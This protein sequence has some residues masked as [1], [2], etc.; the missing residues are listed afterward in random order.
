MAK[1]EE[2]TKFKEKYLVPQSKDA[3]KMWKDVLKE[4]NKALEDWQK[5]CRKDIADWE[6]ETKVSQN[7]LNISQKRLVDN[8]N[9]RKRI[10]KEIS[11]ARQAEEEISGTEPDDESEALLQEITKQILEHEKSITLTKQNISRDN[12]SIEKARNDI[13]KYTDQIE[14]ITT[15]LNSQESEHYFKL[16]EV[17][18][19]DLRDSIGTH[20]W[21]DQVFKDFQKE[22][23]KSYAFANDY[24]SVIADLKHHP[25][26]YK[27]PLMDGIQI[28]LGTLDA[29]YEQGKRSFDSSE[30]LAAEESL[31]ESELAGKGKIVPPVTIFDFPNAKAM[32]LDMGLTKDEVARLPIKGGFSC[33]IGDKD[34][35]VAIATKGITPVQLA[36]AGEKAAADALKLHLFAKAR[37][38]LQDL[39]NNEITSPEAT[40]LWQK[41]IDAA[42][43]V[44][45]NAAITELERQFRLGLQST[46]A[47]IKFGFS[48]VGKV[49][50]AT[51]AVIGVVL[52]GMVGNVAGIVLGVISAVKSVISLIKEV[53][54]FCADI[55]TVIA[56]ATK[57]IDETL[58]KFNVSK[59][60]LKT[61]IAGQLKIKDG[62]KGLTSKFI[63]DITGF[64][65][66]KTFGK[67]SEFLGSARDKMNNMELKQHDTSR[68]QNTALEVQSTLQAQIKELES[69]KDV[70]QEIEKQISL[71]SKEVDKIGEGIMSL[72][73][74][75][76]EQSLIIKDLDKELS[77]L[78]DTVDKLKT[79]K[80]SVKWCE[81]A[82]MGLALGS[83]IG[84]G[85]LTAIPADLLRNLDDGLKI[86]KEVI[87]YTGIASTITSVVV[88]QVKELV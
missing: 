3:E 10:E 33:I 40:K 36:K 72:G 17:D 20:F 7:L 62:L 30:E 5:K 88:D 25:I 35:R 78:E 38:M 67:C 46:L 56:K 66:F 34:T 57:E 26:E 16:E 71:L 21:S 49:L 64:D 83:S 6:Q 52:S 47:K 77:S 75:I 50:G 68:A 27:E 39:D 41:Q 74:S 85:Q 15:K 45:V 37:K 12:N 80:P 28:Y 19:D 8:E 79:L 55:K 59:A 58:K 81:L 53:Q 2:V 4:A 14:H 29:F 18:L 24:A 84:A 60:E 73:D 13:I 69:V 82:G 43:A 23:R 11:E 65:I 1:G 44:A 61:K 63:N 48:V 22:Y 54:L 32:L 87:S 70:P 42:E 86:S 51:G 9:K 31:E 76:I